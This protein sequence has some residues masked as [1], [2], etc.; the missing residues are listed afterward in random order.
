[1]H[2]SGIHYVK[3]GYVKRE[4]AERGA[5]RLIATGL[6]CLVGRSVQLVPVTQ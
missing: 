3:L 6:T 4:R 5:G 1:M 2:R